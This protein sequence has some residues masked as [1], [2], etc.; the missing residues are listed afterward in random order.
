MPSDPQLLH[1]TS[2]DGA[3]QLGI[4]LYHPDG[5]CKAT[6]IYAHCGG[7]SH[8]SRKD[9]TARRLSEKLGPEGVAVASIDYRKKTGI[10]AFE[11]RK[12]KAIEAAQARTARVGMRIN[13]NY[14]GPAFYAALED[15]AAALTYLRENQN[16]LGL[17]APFVALG[18]SAGGIAALS[19]AWPP[20]DGWQDLPRPDAAMGVCAA[21]V[22]PW[23][24]HREGPPAVWMHGCHDG[25][26]SPRNA[27]LIAKKAL[28]KSAPLSVHITPVRGH[29][30]QVTAF[31]EED[32]PDGRPWLDLLRGL[33]ASVNQADKRSS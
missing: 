2:A 24:L 28:E 32:D 13:P 8:G 18:A 7:F 23:R 26:I 4:D 31:L 10:E 12:A 5:P 14:C 15:F 17:S 6:V 11:P 9:K 33:I 3:T 30:Q 29:R 25:V 20:R 16:D 22:Q 27:R 19:L 21:M 1:Y